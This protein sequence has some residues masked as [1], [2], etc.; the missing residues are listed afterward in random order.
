MINL[1]KNVIKADDV[2]FAALADIAQVENDLVKAEEFK[3]KAI[4]IRPR[5]ANRHAELAKFYMEQ[6]NYTKAWP[7]VKRATDLES[8]SAKYQEMALDCAINLNELIEAR[9]RYDKLR[10]LLDDQQRL[11]LFKERID[12]IS[13]IR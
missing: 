12:K 6:G 11:R 7:S 10:L 5:L 13:T 9:K 4:E 1:L 3:L 2:A 8:K